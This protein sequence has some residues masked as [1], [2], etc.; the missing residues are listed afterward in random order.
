MRASSALSL[1][2]DGSKT[3]RAETGRGLMRPRVET[4]PT[5]QAPR[6]RALST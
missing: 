3:A 4:R 2:D 1:E 5:H 6:T